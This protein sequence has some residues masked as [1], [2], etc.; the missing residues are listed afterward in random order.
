[1]QQPTTR[2]TAQRP[3]IANPKPTTAA[4]T[5]PVRTGLWHQSSMEGLDNIPKSTEKMML[6][7]QEDNELKKDSEQLMIY[8]EA[9]RIQDEFCYDVEDVDEKITEAEDEVDNN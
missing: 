9:D 8:P 3:Q 4:T 6:K 7:Q 1:M 2:M 5:V